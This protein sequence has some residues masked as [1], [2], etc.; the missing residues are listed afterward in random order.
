MV[1]DPVCFKLVDETNAAYAVST[2]D[3]TYYFCSTE[4]MNKFE[5]KDVISCEWSIEEWKKRHLRRLV[6]GSLMEPSNK[7]A[8]KR[9]KV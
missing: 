4:C 9:F 1:R 3:A 6:A 5:G 7:D 8:V 2:S